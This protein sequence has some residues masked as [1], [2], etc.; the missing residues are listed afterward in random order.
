M[1]RHTQLRAELPQLGLS[2]QRGSRSTSASSARR[3]LFRQAL[4]LA[5]GLRIE[6]LADDGVVTPGQPV[7]VRLLVANRG[8][9]RPSLSMDL[10]VKGLDGDTVVRARVRV[11]RPAAS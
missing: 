10:R 7:K 11:C 3:R 4:D 1:S 9:R 2:E 6:A 8:H 5:Y